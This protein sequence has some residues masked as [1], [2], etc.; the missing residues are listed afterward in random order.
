MT[1]NEVIE[2]LGLQPLP[3]EGGYFRE[4]YRNATS[5]AIYYLLTPQSHS[6]MHR[7]PGDELY[8]FYRGDPVELLLLHP[9]G[10][11]QVALLG[12]DLHRGQQPQFLVPGGC[13][14]GSHLV[15]GGSWAL[16]GTTMSPGFQFTDFT[17]GNAV[18]L[19]ASYPT[20]AA[21]IRELGSGG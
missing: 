17:P 6:R 18:E 8:H 5:T 1:A 13:W 4:T 15:S 16:L 21:L 2:L 12:S 11:G 9:D 19:A 20:H 3:G 7:L 14:Q 10:S